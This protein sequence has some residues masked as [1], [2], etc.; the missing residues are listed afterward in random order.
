[1]FE[2]ICIHLK[3]DAG[4]S[5]PESSVDFGLIAEAMLFYQK[6]HII[7]DHTFL[8]ILLRRLE[9]EILL[10]YLDAGHLEISYLENGT[11]IQTANSGTSRERHKP[12]L[13]AI[14]DYAWDK[15]SRK[16]IQKASGLSAKGSRRFEIKA[17]RHIKPLLYDRTI[18]QETIQDFAEAE[19]VK[20]AVEGYLHTVAP[21]YQLPNAFIF[22]IHRENDALIVETN[23][24]FS[25]ANRAYHTRFSPQHSSLNAAYLLSNLM[26]VREDSYFA[27]KYNSELAT[28]RLQSRILELKFSE[29]LAARQKSAA[30]VSMFQ[31]FVFEDSRAIGDAIRLRN[32]SFRD[33]LKILNRASKFKEWLAGKDIDEGLLKEYFK[34]IAAD[35][36]VD[37][38]PSKA[39]RWAI[40]QAA[41]LGV[42]ALGG[43][44]VGTALALAV[45]A[46][47]TF[48]LDKL[49]KGWRPNQFVQR[50]KEFIPEKTIGQRLNS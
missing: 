7:A 42:D 33:L 35:S 36:W 27:S 34:T 11:G 25:A 24:D 12:I 5:K 9:P 37:K 6:V 23:I 48:L 17:S 1:M 19:Y 44:G 22:R 50:V 31:D 28:D 43:K 8:A 16:L 10:E 20:S 15:H 41:G 2:S 47:D 26:A 38:L 32:R 21:E 4:N 45:G 18:E 3:N 13:F 30:E 29:L 49:I 14:S 39:I 40:F 46:G